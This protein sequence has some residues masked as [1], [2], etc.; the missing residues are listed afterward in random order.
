[1]NGHT[2]NVLYRPNEFKLYVTGSRVKL[3]LFRNRDN[4]NGAY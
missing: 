2:Q 4:S 1:M 3:T